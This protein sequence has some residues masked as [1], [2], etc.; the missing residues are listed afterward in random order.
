MFDDMMK[1]APTT[2]TT[3]CTTS[4]EKGQLWE[5][6]ACLLLVIQTSATPCFNHHDEICPSGHI[7]Q[8]KLATQPQISCLTSSKNSLLL[9]KQTCN[10]HQND[11][12]NQMIKII[13]GSSL[14]DQNSRSYSHIYA[15]QLANLLAIKSAA[16]HAKIG[17]LICTPKGISMSLPVDLERHGIY[18]NVWNGNL[19]KMVSL[20]S[21]SDQKQGK[22]YQNWSSNIIGCPTCQNQLP[23]I[24]SHPTC[25]I[26]QN[27][28]LNKCVKMS[29]RASS[30]HHQQLNKT[31]LITQKEQIKELYGDVFEGIGHFPGK[32][33][34]INLDESVTPVQTR[35]RPVPVHLKEVFKQEITKCLL[36]VSWNQLK[37]QLPGSTA[38]S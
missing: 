10:L 8:P 9:V 12:L 7:N 14:C 6:P 1:S 38:L 11:C 30:Q 4:G 27:N 21:M 34:H 20:K 16:W 18:Q 35:C 3:D 28:H 31:P 19:V 32:A 29:H 37:K 24:I 23:N 22:S 13:P 2:P 25:A 33:Y 17:H 15:F 36:Q 5:A 26:H